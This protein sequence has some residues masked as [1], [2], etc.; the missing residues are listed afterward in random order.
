MFLQYEEFISE[1]NKKIK[2]GSDF[3]LKLLQTVISNPNRYCGLFRLSNA[4]TKLIQN[5]TQSNEIK[6]GDFMESIVTLY[7]AKLGY[8]NLNKAAGRDE[9]GNKLN[10]D[11]LFMKDETIYMVEQKIRDDH[12]STKKRGQFINFD[13]KLQ[14]I[15][16]LYPKYKII[17]ITWFIDSTLVKNRKFYLNEIK[18]INYPNVELFLYYGEQFFD[19]LENG[20]T[21]WQEILKHL[22]QLRMSNNN[23][24]VYIPDF[25]NDEEIYQALLQLPV[26]Y[27]RKLNSNKEQYRQLRKE[28]FSNGPNLERV[29]ENR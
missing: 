18:T 20:A 7:I 10:T 11:Q 4:K 24:L 6:F 3:Y 23:D 2:S 15:R 5:V 26:S 9:N 17:G 16:R 8:T 29:K 28:L 19:S 12:D 25:A 13:K 1:L 27:W 14:L 21:A 22:M